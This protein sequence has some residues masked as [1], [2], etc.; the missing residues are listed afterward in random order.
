MDPAPQKNFQCKSRS[1]ET[2]RERSKLRRQNAYDK[3]QLGSRSL[4]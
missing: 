1:L 3:R 2:K 4:E